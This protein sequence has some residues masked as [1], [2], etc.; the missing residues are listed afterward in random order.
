MIK[1][2]DEETLRDDNIGIGIKSNENQINYLSLATWGV[3]ARSPEPKAHV[4]NVR[5]FRIEL[6]FRKVVFLRK[7]ENRSTQRKTSRSRE[8]NQQQTRPT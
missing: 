7:G 2:K 4:S 6:E 8:E 3:V 1:L 5:A